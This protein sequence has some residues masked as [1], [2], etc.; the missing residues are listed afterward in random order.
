MLSPQ[1]TS[2]TWVVVPAHNESGRIAA[3]LADL[4]G[5]G[6]SSKH[7]VVV[8]DGS[9]DDTARH[10][11]SQNVWVL[12]HIVNRGQGAALQTGID[13]ALARK[14]E[15]IVTFDADGQ[16]LATDIPT[17]LKPIDQGNAQI[18]LGSRF[19]GQAI[20]VPTLRKLILR[21]AVWGTRLTTRLPLTD[22]HN[23]LRAMTA[24]AAA[25]LRLSE[26]GMAHAS[27]LLSKLSRSGLRWQE[28]PVTICYTEQ[29]LVKGQRNRAAFEIAFRMFVAKLVG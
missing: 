14:A 5:V 8:D 3:V 4:R 6:V 11:S 19:L 13:F 1:L 16:H 26:D 7:I 21:V 29:T 17:L 12:Q 2:R 15:I 23:G 25:K 27:E 18:V 9:S 20:G 10:A 28:V 24:A 22:T